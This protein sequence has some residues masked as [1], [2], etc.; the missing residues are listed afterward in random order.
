MV[1]ERY[2]N[3]GERYMAKDE[4]RAIGYLFGSIMKAVRWN[5]E[6][7]EENDGKLLG[8]FKTLSLRPCSSQTVLSLASSHRMNL[9]NN[10]IKNLVNGKLS[11]QQ[12][13]NHAIFWDEAE[14]INYLNDVN[15]EMKNARLSLLQNNIDYSLHYFFMEGGGQTWLEYLGPA[16]QQYFKQ[17][18]EK[19]ARYVQSKPDKNVPR[20][21]TSNSHYSKF[22]DYDEAK[23]SDLIRF[24][25]NLRAHYPSDTTTL[26]AAL[27][28]EIPYNLKLFLGYFFNRFPSL[29]TS[30][31]VLATKY[32]TGVCL[33][34]R[35]LTELLHNDFYYR[36]QDRI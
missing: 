20:S 18:R 1:K 22:T 28:L 15:M 7:Q 36:I 16:G 13:L 21:S 30:S 12:A 31:F 10:L 26:S 2:F 14:I 5:P 24:I 33:D 6:N 25:R 8:K 19:S 32:S 11:L 35:N 3:A 4:T 9:I 34:G 23:F 29:L 17:N 27:A